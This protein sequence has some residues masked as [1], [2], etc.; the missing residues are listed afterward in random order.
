MCGTTGRAATH[1]ARKTGNLKFIGV[2]DDHT[3]LA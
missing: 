3:R 1:R 2:I